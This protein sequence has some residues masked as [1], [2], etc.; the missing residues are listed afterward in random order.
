MC[1]TRPLWSRCAQFA[2]DVLRTIVRD[3]VH[4]GKVQLVFRGLAFLGPDFVGRRAGTL[5]RLPVQALTVSEF[6]A[7]L[8]TVVK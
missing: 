8:D 2:V 1:F 3:Y 7:A 4:T 6:R 5:Q